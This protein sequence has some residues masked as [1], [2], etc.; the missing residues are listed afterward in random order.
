[1]NPTV[2][3]ELVQRLQEAADLLRAGR[4]GE[5]F[6]ILQS[7]LAQAWGLAE[8]HRLMGVAL[9][10]G[11][12]LS[13]AERAFRTAL[14]LDPALTAAA[15]NLAEVLMSAGR[16]VEAEQ[17]VRPFAGGIRPDVEALD[18]L[19][20]T[21]KAQGRQ[22]DALTVYE[23]AIAAAPASAVAEHNLAAL[24][25]DMER[26]EEAEAAARRALGKGSGAPETLLVL[27]R[28]LIGQGRNAEA[29]EALLSAARRRPGD[30]Q[31]QADLAQLVWMR[32]GDLAAARASLD[33]ALADRPGD[34]GLT[35][36]LAELVEYAKGPADAWR[37]LAAVAERPDAGGPVQVLA[38]RFLAGSDPPRAVVFARAAVARDGND[39]VALSALV[40]ALLAAG[41]VEEAEETAARMTSL[42]PLDQYAW[43]LRHTAWRL[44][45]D[46]R[47]LALSDY[48]SLVGAQRLDT[49]K[50]WLDLSSYLNDLEQSLRRLHTLHTHP[51]GQS[52]RHGSQTSRSLNLVDDPAVK[53]FFEAVDG[54]IRRH[55]AALG[56]GDDQVR[57]RNT[58]GYR[59][60]GCWSIRLRPH[61]F[62]ADHL[63]PMGWLSS[64]CYIALP[65]AVDHGRQGWLKFGEPGIAT[66]PA[67][68]AEHFV[69]PEPGLLV[70]FPSYMW[71]GTV[72]F[73]GE[74]E[75][76]TIAFDLV[77]E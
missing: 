12:D 37:E 11:G 45:G 26:V 64:A 50:G 68:Q 5:A 31:I 38:S 62:H 71:H 60:A 51:V 74:E 56:R 10:D 14:S 66:V 9:R 4:A 24:L 41:L 15:T 1:M 3:P 30:R 20:R 44:M 55:L 72:P 59:F 19:A 25:G 23:R 34:P 40:Q 61:G 17:T 7:V 54:P 29:E 21:L 75:R 73:D 43:G 42:A 27:G 49:P 28:A 32:T 58:G 33:A 16:G 52:V 53:A 2:S 6:P 57:S 35:I 22:D 46:Q 36:A 76:L 77:P 70:L 69:K 67:L 48:A 8:A 65:T 39:R 47:A 18:T 13:Q 63:H